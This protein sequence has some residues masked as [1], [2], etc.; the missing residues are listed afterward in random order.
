[1]RSITCLIIG[2]AVFVA[3]FTSCKNDKPTVST[4]STK[5]TPEGSIVLADSLVYGIATQISEN[6]DPNESEEFKLF[7]QK[8]LVNY[9]FEQLYAKKLKAYDFLTGEEL[10]L[11]DLK[12]I[13][14][15]EGFSR[16]KV[17]KVQFNEQWYFDKN[18]VLNKRVNSMTFGIEHY[19]NQGTFLNYNALFTIRFNTTAQ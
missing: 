5:T 16:S 6:S 11:K 3:T 2:V 18:G 19:S 15:A 8:K 9:I 10:S 1:M 12:K 7:L 13:E 17:G 4:I 14:A